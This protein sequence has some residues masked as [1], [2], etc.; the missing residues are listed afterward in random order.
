MASVIKQLEINSGAVQRLTKELNYRNI[1]VDTEKQRV[2]KLE[3]EGAD[4]W[5]VRKQVRASCALTL[6]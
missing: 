2:A 3:S 6:C 1:D 5:T 4:E